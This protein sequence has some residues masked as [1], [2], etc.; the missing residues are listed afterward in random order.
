MEKWKERCMKLIRKNNDLIEKAVSIQEQIEE[1]LS[2][3]DMDL[4]DYEMSKTANLLGEY[5]SVAGK[6]NEE[7]IEAYLSEAD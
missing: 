7:A 5:G 2:K 3:H 4:D 6:L 1:I